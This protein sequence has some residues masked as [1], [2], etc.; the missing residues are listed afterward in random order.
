MKAKN[1]NFSAENSGARYGCG[2]RIYLQLRWGNSYSYECK[3]NEI[4][5]L[6][7]KNLAH[8][9]YWQQKDYPV[10][11]ANRTSDGSICWMDVG[12]YLKEKGKEEKTSVKQI[13]IMILIHQ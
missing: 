13:K 6:T 8:A 3:D 5:V 1:I 4:E 9:S 7:I 12:A 11:L 2:K 10:M